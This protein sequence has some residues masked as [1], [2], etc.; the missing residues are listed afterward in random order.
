MKLIKYDIISIKTYT[1][2]TIWKNKGVVCKDMGKWSFENS[3]RKVLNKFLIYFLFFQIKI[4]PLNDYYT[5]Q[6]IV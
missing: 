6:D 5:G 4:L 3:I 1:T 2:N